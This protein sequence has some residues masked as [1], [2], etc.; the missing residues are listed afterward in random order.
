[1]R[2]PKPWKNSEKRE[3]WLGPRGPYITISIVVD[4]NG[5]EVPSH[6]IFDELVQTRQT[7]S[8]AHAALKEARRELR[9]QGEPEADL[10]RQM[11]AAVTAGGRALA[12]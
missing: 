8:K 3:Q 5:D 1:M 10:S 2:Y 12:D 11:N 4:A 7:L 9:K 6:V